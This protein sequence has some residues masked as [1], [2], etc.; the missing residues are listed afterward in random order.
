M[1]KFYGFVSFLDVTRLRWFG[2]ISVKL[3]YLCLYGWDLTVLYT[4]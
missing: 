2:A 1:K 4:K 3:E